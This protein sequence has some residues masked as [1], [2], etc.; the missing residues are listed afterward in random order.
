MTDLSS[1]AVSP[2][3]LDF[4]QQKK[5]AKDLLREYRARDSRAFKRFQ[6]HHPRFTREAM[7]G[8]EAKLA[9][10]Q[11][12]I[13]RE[14][15]AASWARLKAHIAAMDNAERLISSQQR[16][17]DSE[18][19]TLHLRCGR[20][21]QNTLELAGFDGDFLEYRDPVCQGPLVQGDDY[22]SL[23]CD[24]IA[25][26]YGGMSREQIMSGALEDERRL[27]GC[28]H[29]YE[30]VVLWFE[31]DTHDQLML[32]K[33]LAHFHTAARPRVLE[34][35]SLNQFPG[36]ERFIGL[37][38]LPPEAI[39][40]LWSAREP[41]ESA[42]LS[43]AAAAWRALCDENPEHL[44]GLL[45]RPDCRALPHLSAA[46][47]RHLQELP[48][49]ANGLGLTEELSLEILREEPRTCGQ[50]F[51][52]LVLERE[53]MP[54]LGDLMFWY[55]LG[56]LEQ[57]AE[58]LVAIDRVDGE[59]WPRWPAA[60]TETGLAVLTEEVDYLS[61]GPPERWVGG[62]RITGARPSWRW[63]ARTGKVRQQ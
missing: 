51:R 17:P 63:D 10:A 15:G 34:L 41:I 36:R 37:G 43:L 55:I 46:V 28:A 50:V 47:G 58:P 6:Q 20:D 44:A 60:I 14:L 45:A 9:D 62:V 21:I 59:A 52:A 40:L 12:V 53:P 7:T 42:Q 33:V 22:L 4:E 27:Q 3:R 13:A 2:F 48:S 16:S 1:R 57:S 26:A 54:W 19:K 11:L 35:V 18:M 61:L 38:Q 8:L 25:Q 29:S 49:V 24:F 39:H 5:R 32:V 56:Q 31:H 30:R 23:R